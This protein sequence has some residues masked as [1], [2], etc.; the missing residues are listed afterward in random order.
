MFDRISSLRFTQIYLFRT[1]YGSSFLLL[2]YLGNRASG[3]MLAL[4]I[5]CLQ[6]KVRTAI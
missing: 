3:M 5:A 4:G 1:L 2:S 6:S